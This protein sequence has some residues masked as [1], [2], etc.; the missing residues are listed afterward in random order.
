LPRKF[1]LSSL[2]HQLV[3][4]KEE[5][6]LSPASSSNQLI[7]NNTSQ[8][9]K[10]TEVFTTPAVQKSETGNISTAKENTPYKRFNIKVQEINNHETPY[11]HLHSHLVESHIQV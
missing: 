11:S 5:A 9:K 7:R 10:P 2:T 3:D 1:T 8:V 4:R 6:D